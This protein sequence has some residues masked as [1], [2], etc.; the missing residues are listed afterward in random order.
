MARRIWVPL[1]AAILAAAGAGSWGEGGPAGGPV[2]PDGNGGPGNGNRSGF[3]SAD[4]FE[5][6]WAFKTGR[7]VSSPVVDEDGNLYFGSGDGFLYALNRKG[8]LLWKYEAG[9]WLERPALGADGSVLAT[10]KD[11]TLHCLS[12]GG[13]EKWR[14]QIACEIG[15]PPKVAPDGSILIT[16]GWF[17]AERDDHLYCIGPAGALLWK[18]SIPGGLS[19]VPAVRRDGSIVFPS[20]E[21]ALHSVGQDGKS[22]WKTAKVMV[23]LKEPAV[24]DDGNVYFGSSL[25]GAVF[26]YSGQSASKW[27]YDCRELQEEFHGLIHPTIPALSADSIVYGLA[28]SVPGGAGAGRDGDPGGRR[29]PS[30]HIHEGCTGLAHL[31][32]ERRPSRA[33]AANGRLVLF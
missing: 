4:K 15:V 31:P 23:W 11:G 3:A 32:Q 24:D 1:P 8:E 6:A 5:A 28:C 9:D 25:S 22:L 29:D 10:C 17:Q 26:C 18:T 2:W 13:K 16:P 33:S 7:H 30:P 19:G 12:R 27:Q 21:G 20:R 14:Y